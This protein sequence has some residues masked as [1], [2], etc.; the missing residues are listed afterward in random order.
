MIKLRCVIPVI[1]FLVMTSASQAIALTGTWTLYPPQSQT[2]SEVSIDPPINADGTSVWSAKSVVPVQYDLLLGYG[3]VVFSSYQSPSTY[4]YLDFAPSSPI[5]FAQLTNLQAVYTFT[6]GT[7]H[8]GALRWSVN[9]SD[10]STIFI[11]YGKDSTFWIDCS[12]NI[13]DTTIDQSGLNMVNANFD[14]TGGDVRYERSPDFANIYVNYASASAF[15]AGK[16]ITSVTLVLDAGWGGDQL[17]S[18]GH[19]TVNDNT[20]MPKSGTSPTCPSQPATIQVS[21]I[22]SAGSL[23]I[24]ENLTSIQKD[25][26][27]QFRIVDC[28]YMYNIAGKSLG[29]G[30]YK[31]DAI[32]NGL[33]VYQQPPGT[34]FGLK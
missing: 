30:Q 12:S 2:V 22:G 18:L 13:N 15:A 23:S 21:K 32:I 3:P 5:T 9:F 27:T 20:F 29:A 26:G 8:G 25:T 31:V 10:G 28:K 16:T 11:Y 14:G 33:P 6:T 7:C 17:V 19:V 4:S 24:D 34:V 1:A